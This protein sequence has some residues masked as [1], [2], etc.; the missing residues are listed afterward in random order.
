MENLSLGSEDFKGSNVE[1]SFISNNIEKGKAVPVGTVSNGYKKEAEGKWVP[2]KE[3]KDGYKKDKPSINTDAMADKEQRRKEASEARPKATEEDKAYFKENKEGVMAILEEDPFMSVKEAIDQ[4]KEESDSKGATEK[5]STLGKAAQAI[6]KVA[7]RFSE[8]LQDAVSLFD[9]G[10][11]SKEVKKAESG[12]SDFSLGTD[13]FEGSGIEKGMGGFEGDTIEKGRKVPVGTVTNGYKKMAEGKWV[14]V[15]K[16][17][18]STSGGS[19]SQSNSGKSVASKMK[20]AMAGGQPVFSPSAIEKVS[21]MD[22]VTYSDLEK[23]VPDYVAGKELSKVLGSGPK[24]SETKDSA[25]KEKIDYL[26]NYEK[27]PKEVQSLIGEYEEHEGDYEKMKELEGKLSK[28]GWDMDY[29]LDGTITD[30]QPKK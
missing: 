10:N 29:G 7:K 20:G 22:K 9:E 19:N 24:P 18:K 14:P 4:Y 23:I 2:V 17:G 15:K 1:K 16:E 28:I 30:L 8:D 27:Q 5:A 12:T 3:G 21:K 6:E 25:P 26:E 11:K 13:A